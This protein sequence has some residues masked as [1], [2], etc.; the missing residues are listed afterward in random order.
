MDFGDVGATPQDQF[1]NT[2]SSDIGHFREKLQKSTLERNSNITLTNQQKNYGKKNNVLRSLELVKSN[3]SI[4][5]NSLTSN[6]F[7]QY[8]IKGKFEDDVLE[9]TLR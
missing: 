3:L 4:S 9:S 2:G 8:E 6:F 5:P 1:Q 7:F